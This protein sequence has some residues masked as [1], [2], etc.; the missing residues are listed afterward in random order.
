MDSQENNE[1][2]ESATGDGNEDK[3]PKYTA[4]QQQPV[5][6]RFN[7]TG[8]FIGFEDEESLTPTYTPP[9]SYTSLDLDSRF[10]PDGKKQNFISKL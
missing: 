5:L 6:P 7:S 10:F 4:Q 8:P 1:I 2:S 3:N 9:R